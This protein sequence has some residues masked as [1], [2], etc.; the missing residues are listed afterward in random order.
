MSTIQL[1]TIINAPV[2]AVF[3]LSLNIDFHMQSMNQSQEKAIAGVTSGCIKKGE[4][5][6]WRG[7]HFGLWLTHASL[8]TEY[9]PYTTF[10]DEMIKGRFK[11]FHHKHIFI[12]QNGS[13]KM[14]DII[15][16]KTPYGLAGEFFDKTVLYNYLTR[17][18]KKRNAHLKY[19]L[20]NGGDSAFAKA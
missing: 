11:S 20:E 13:T 7:K 16:Y 10:V 1:E 19:T 18:I 14:Q 2:A 9:E 4:T 3:K 12:D 17:L 8:I 5:V 15:T 6:T